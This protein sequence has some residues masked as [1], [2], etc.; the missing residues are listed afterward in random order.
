M[1][2]TSMISAAGGVMWAH[3]PSNRERRI[4]GEGTATSTENRTLATAKE[5]EKCVV[6]ISGAGAGGPFKALG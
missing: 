2:S 3:A 5:R 4:G 6:K 1:C